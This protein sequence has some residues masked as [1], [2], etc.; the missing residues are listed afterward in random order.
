[1]GAAESADTLHTAL[2]SAKSAETLHN[3]LHAAKSA[4][5]LYSHSAALR[6]PKSVDSLD[7]HYAELR[8]AK[9]AGSVHAAP[10][11]GQ[12][13][14]RG[15]PPTEEDTIMTGKRLALLLVAILLSVLLI[16]LDQTILATALPRIA[17][18]FQSFTLQGWVSTSFIMSQTIFLLFYGQVLRI[19]PAKWVLV[20]A[21]SIFEIG[22]LLCG[23]SQNINQLITGRTVSGVGAA[24]IFLSMFQILAQVVRLEDRPRLFG[25][26]GAVFG[27][28][29]II[30]PLIGGAF[31]DHVTWRW[32]F[33]INLPVG[34]V[35]LIAVALIMKASPPLGS[36]PSNRSWP[37]LLRQVARM[38]FLGATLVAGAVTSVVLALQWGGNTK[39]WDD[40]AVIVCFVVS[41]V[42]TV[43]FF[44]WE[45]Y[46]GDRAMTP[47]A[48]MKS[49]SIYAILG[50]CFLGR[51]SGLI[52][53]YYIP[54]FYQAVRHHSATKS[55][56]DI[57]PFLLS[58]VL[59]LAVSG[60]IGGKTGYYWHFLFISPF[61]LAVG[62]GLF[63]TIG[64]NTSSGA[65][66][67]FQI[68]VGIGTG[69]GMQNSLL[70]IQVEFKDNP[71]ILGQATALADFAQLLGGTLGLGMAEP[72]FASTLGKYLVRYAPDAPAAIVKQSPTEI[73]TL[74]AA[75]IPGVVL[76]YTKAL[77]IVFILGVP[78]AVLSL[79]FS[80]F[81]KNIRILKEEESAAETKTTA[82]AS[83]P[84]KG[85][86]AQ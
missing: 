57:L 70:A 20:T 59:A 50:T 55:G 18:D 78:A 9:S 77:Q 8:A 75:Q 32:C 39:P 41:G 83:D 28:A 21:I 86:E 22:S 25:M 33:Y 30:G 56:L 84:E 62:S 34:G 52:L 63:Y 82:T 35:S 73:Y 7:A 31:S 60:V 29:S 43:M 47:M 27:L 12:E 48:I 36:D 67:G 79:V 71:K 68:L 2:R 4:D 81:I 19:F 49:M 46:L 13:K 58:S 54:I 64:T 17:S 5:T 80:V 65:I 76:A 42:L 66:A 44:A 16:A 11:D 10:E 23:V 37:E 40:K 1:M 45:T 69:M 74:P 72:V 3:T 61:F 15:S 26:F 6:S 24:G 14:G 51:F 85:A 53:S 38:D